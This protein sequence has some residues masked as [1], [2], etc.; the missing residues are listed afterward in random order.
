M[1]LFNVLDEECLFP[2]GSDDT[3]LEKMKNNFSRNPIFKPAP[4]REAPLSF[5][6]QH[7]AGNVTYNA[8]GFLDKNRDT[9]FEDL[10]ILCYGS[11]STVMVEMFEVQ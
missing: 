5:S 8:K 2:K 4:S 10:K 1:G 9:F 11:K 7:Y 3:F 6:V